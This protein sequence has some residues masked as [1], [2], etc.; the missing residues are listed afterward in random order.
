MDNANAATEIAASSHSPMPSVAPRPKITNQPGF[1]IRTVDP[2]QKRILLN[3]IKTSQSH[4]HKRYPPTLISWDNALDYITFIT[5]HYAFQNIKDEIRKTLKLHYND[6]K[7]HITPIPYFDIVPNPAVPLKELQMWTHSTDHIHTLENWL[8]QHHYI[9]NKPTVQ[10]QTD[11]KKFSFRWQI[12]VNIDIHTVIQQ[13][14]TQHNHQSCQLR[15]STYDTHILSMKNEAVLKLRQMTKYALSKCQT[16]NVPLQEHM[17]YLRKKLIS[18]DPPHL[19]P[20]EIPAHILRFP[21]LS[22]L[23]SRHFTINLIHNQRRQ[24]KNSLYEYRRQ[25]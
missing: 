8:T 5:P 19:F 18:K 11:H 25:R 9:D 13:W 20:F 12:P 15:V 4:F 16:T 22:I 24:T 23:C 21:F 14:N 6:I 7:I 3:Y 1:M 10:L 17:Y 2:R